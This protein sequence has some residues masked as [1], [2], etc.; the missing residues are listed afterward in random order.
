MVLL[1]FLVLVHRYL[2]TLFDFG[3]PNT[4]SNI[5]FPME[6]IFYCLMDP[7]KVRLKVIH[8]RSRFPQNE[9]KYRYHLFLK[10]R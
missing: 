3:N 4:P 9:M 6:V 10:E 8:L 5:R 1:Q 7:V 2:R